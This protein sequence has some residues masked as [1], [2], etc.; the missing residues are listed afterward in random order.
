MKPIGWA[1]RRVSAQLRRQAGDDRLQEDGEF[2]HPVEDGDDGSDHVGREVERT[3]QG[4]DDTDVA[5]LVRLLAYGDE[6]PR[7]GDE[8]GRGCARPELRRVSVRAEGHDEG[9][10][11]DCEGTM[12][13][14]EG[15]TDLRG[16][17]QPQSHHGHVP[18]DEGGGEHPARVERHR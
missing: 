16:E 11:G 7:E 3:P 18:A 6:R 12:E 1:A 4:P 9:G 15:N 14:A 10:N 8:E 17:R 13:G 5:L 2:L